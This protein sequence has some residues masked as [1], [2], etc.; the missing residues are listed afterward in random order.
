MFPQHDLPAGLLGKL[1][2]P[3]PIVSV[4]VFGIFGTGS[5][6]HGVGE[7]DGGV[8]GVGLGGVSVGGA[9]DGGEGL[10]GDGGEELVGD[11]G[12]ELVGLGGVGEGGKGLAGT[13][14]TSALA[15]EVV[16]TI[17]VVKNDANFMFCCCVGRQGPC[18]DKAWTCSSK[19]FE[20]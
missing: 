5:G 14:N 18:M 4:R 1:H 17:P 9:G 8:G 20:L 19:I 10:V 2:S 13:A 15:L 12:E 16:K 6:T 7:L 3:L 11:G